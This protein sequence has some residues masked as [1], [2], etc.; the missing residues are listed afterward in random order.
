MQKNEKGFSAVEALLL[1]VIIGVISGVGWF[2][3]KQRATKALNAGT[4]LT[5]KA[6]VEP[7]TAKT[8]A[9]QEDQVCTVV[10]QKGWI[11]KTDQAS[12]VSYAVDSSWPDET[13]VTVYKV[14]QDIPVGYGAP[15]SVRFN[16]SS[17]AWEEYELGDKRTNHIVKD[18][19]AK[20]SGSLPTAILVTGDGPSSEIRILFVKDSQVIQIALPAVEWCST[21]PY[22]AYTEYII[23]SITIK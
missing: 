15:V 19:S 1:V 13:K 9:V 18:A 3:W 17:K 2:V 21:N 14:G 12:R 10:T 5:Q 6:Q 16:P 11:T 4:Y 20:V 8:P 7:E 22:S 23:K